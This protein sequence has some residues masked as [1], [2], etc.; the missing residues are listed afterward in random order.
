VDK[1]FW[2]RRRS[3]ELDDGIEAATDDKVASNGAADE[4]DENGVEDWTRGEESCVMDD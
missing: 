4:V 2:L 1:G 3:G